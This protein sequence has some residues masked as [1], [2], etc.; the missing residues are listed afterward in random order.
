MI[1]DNA[2]SPAVVLW[3][4]R[5]GEPAYLQSV[6]FDDGGHDDGA[7]ADAVFAATLPGLLNGQRLD[8]HIR[9]VNARDQL[10]TAPEGE[11][12]RGDFHS[13][14]LWNNPEAVRRE[15]VPLFPLSWSDVGPDPS[16]LFTGTRNLNADPRFQYPLGNDF[17]LRTGS[18]FIGAGRDGSDQGTIPYAPPPGFNGWVSR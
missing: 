11:G 7:P 8:Y 16:G 3:H 5:D 18:P 1:D 17:S 4:L 14:V 15:G 12:T 2:S 13:L 6:M 10:T 9:A